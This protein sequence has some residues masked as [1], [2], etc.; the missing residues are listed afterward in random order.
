MNPS[1]QMLHA[2]R[3][4]ADFP[5]KLVTMLNSSSTAKPVLFSWSSDSDNFQH[6]DFPWDCDHTYTSTLP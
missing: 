3:V 2:E 5:S 4:E 1:K 6:K